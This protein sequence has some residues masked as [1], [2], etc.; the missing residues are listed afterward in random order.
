MIYLGWYDDTKKKTETKIDEAIERYEFKYGVSPNVCLV[1]EKELVEHPRVQVRP[2][3]HLR[4][5]YYY[6]GIEEAD[7]TPAVA[8]PLPRNEAAQAA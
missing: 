1:S 7:S 8:N 2:V 6:V 5:N 4:P 3:R